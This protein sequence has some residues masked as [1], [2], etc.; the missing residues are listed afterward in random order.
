MVPPTPG[1]AEL[2]R[3]SRPLGAVLVLT[4]LFTLALGFV[5]SLPLRFSPAG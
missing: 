3:L 1:S 5:F 4:G 2:Q